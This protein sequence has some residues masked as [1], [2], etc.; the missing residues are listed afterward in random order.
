VTSRGLNLTSG[1]HKPGS[2]DS[3]IDLQRG[4]AKISDITSGPPRSWVPISEVLALH[5]APFDEKF[6]IIKKDYDTNTEVDNKNKKCIP[7]LNKKQRKHRQGTTSYRYYTSTNEPQHAESEARCK[8]K[9]IPRQ[10][11][12]SKYSIAYSPKAS[13]IW[14]VH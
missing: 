4:G 7:T 6:Q 3:V 2:G 11:P 13:R 8:N 9:T 10:S 5:S 14:H 12:D 1:G